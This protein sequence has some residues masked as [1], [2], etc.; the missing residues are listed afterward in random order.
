MTHSKYFCFL[1]TAVLFQPSTTVNNTSIVFYRHS[2]FSIRVYS[3]T[4]LSREYKIRPA[5]CPISIKR[6]YTLYSDAWTNS[7]GPLLLLYAYLIE[8]QAPRVEDSVTIQPS[9]FHIDTHWQY[10]TRWFSVLKHESVWILCIQLIGYFWFVAV[11]KKSV[12]LDIGYG[13]TI[14]IY[15]DRDGVV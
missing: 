8:K 5:I 2:Y 9:G 7:I 15:S 14:I 1:C 4:V 12:C 6:I 3:R 10:G 11:R 13:V